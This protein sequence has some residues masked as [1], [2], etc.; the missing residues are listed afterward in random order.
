[1]RLVLI[2][3]KVLALPDVAHKIAEDGGVVM[4]AAATGSGGLA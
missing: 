2:D 1:V 4:V 3:V